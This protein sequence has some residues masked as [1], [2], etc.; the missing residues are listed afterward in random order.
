MKVGMSYS[1]CVCDIVDGKV[2]IDDVLVIIARTNFDPHNDEHWQEIWQGY[3]NDLGY[4]RPE[5]ITYPPEMEPEF[6]RISIELWNTGKLHQPR[7][8]GQYVHRSSEVWLN[9]R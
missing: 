9:V 2:N 6:R 5:W 7:M 4:S 8:Y 3:R 1:R